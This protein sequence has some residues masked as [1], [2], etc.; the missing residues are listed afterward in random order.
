MRFNSLVCEMFVLTELDAMQGFGGVTSITK[1]L[2]FQRLSNSV[3]IN[4]PYLV[5]RCN[6]DA[7]P[8]VCHR[9]A[10][11]HMASKPRLASQAKAVLASDGS[12]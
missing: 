3:V 4:P 11:R 2:C 8:V 6:K 9:Q 7:A 10:S 1:T 12:E 5:T